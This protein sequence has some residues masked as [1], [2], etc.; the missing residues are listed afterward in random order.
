[1]AVRLVV[2]SLG[3]SVPTGVVC[4]PAAGAIAILVSGRDAGSNRLPV[5]RKDILSS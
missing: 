3:L 2:V 5:T 4:P 1:M